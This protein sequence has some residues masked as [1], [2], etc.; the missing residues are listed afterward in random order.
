MRTQSVASE[1]QKW[2]TL[3]KSTRR[4]ST[5]S[6]S[7][8]YEGD[9]CRDTYIKNTELNR[10]YLQSHFAEQA[11]ETDIKCLQSDRL[12]LHPGSSAVRRTTL[13]T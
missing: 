1:K 7:K 13:D 6:I 5:V 11:A 2:L 4:E 8:F 12:G 3:M 9:Y 10:K